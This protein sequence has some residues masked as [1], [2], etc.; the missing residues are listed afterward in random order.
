MSGE[1][2]SDSIWKPFSSSVVAS[3]VALCSS[4]TS[5][6]TV[7]RMPAAASGSAVGCVRHS[8][9]P[10]FMLLAWTSQAA[11]TPPLSNRLTRM[12]AAVSAKPSPLRRSITPPAALPC[13]APPLVSAAAVTISIARTAVSP[14]GSA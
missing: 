11:S 2:A 1:L 5:T 6:R 12:R 4:S 13:A 9:V 10:V 14:C 7:H 8:I 3:A